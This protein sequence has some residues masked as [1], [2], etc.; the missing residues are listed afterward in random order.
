MSLLGQHFLKGQ[1][2]AKLKLAE[3]KT[4]DSFLSKIYNS[5]VIGCPDFS[6]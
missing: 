5:N 2:E 3:G 1:S 6:R 4:P